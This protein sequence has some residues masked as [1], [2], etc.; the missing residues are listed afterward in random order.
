LN[1]NNFHDILAIQVFPGGWPLKGSGI[2]E[3]R[4]KMTQKGDYIHETFEIS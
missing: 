3:H 4:M 2:F 1:A